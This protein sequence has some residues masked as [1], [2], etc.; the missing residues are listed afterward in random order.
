MSKKKGISVPSEVG[1][2]GIP[3]GLGSRFPKKNS[4]I[5]SPA[6]FGGKGM[7]KS[8]YPGGGKMD[9]RLD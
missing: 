4:G 6:E 3:P 7:P 5:N 8:S 1:G 2:K 9:P